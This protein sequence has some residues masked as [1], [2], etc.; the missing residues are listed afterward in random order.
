MANKI[1]ALGGL[2]VAQFTGAFNDNAF[3][4]F[5]VFF[6]IDR[7]LEPAPA[8]LIQRQFSQAMIAFVGPLLLGT[9]LAMAWLDRCSKRNVLVA[10]KF[11]EAS[12]FAGATIAI[13]L[14]GEFQFWMF[15]LISALG[16]QTAFLSPAKSSL[17]PGLV[18]HEKL[19]EANGAVEFVTFVAM[20]L[21]TWS[22]G[23]FKDQFA[24]HLWLIPLALL[25]LSLVGIAA[26]M[27]VPCDVPSV[28][29]GSNS[30]QR[31][32]GAL[33]ATFSQR[34]LFLAAVGMALSWFVIAMLVQLVLT[35]GKAAQGLGLN[36]RD[37][38][39]PIILAGIGAG[40]GSFWVGKL[41]RRKVEI[42]WIP[43][44]AAMLTLMVAVF[45]GWL[46]GLVGTA[47]FCAGVGMT[48]GFVLVPLNALLQWQAPEAKRG[49][50]IAVSN[51]A[52][53]AGL[54]GGTL[55]AQGVGDAGLGL[56]GS[57]LLIAAIAGIAT[58][59]VVR[60]FPE[61]L[62]RLCGLLLMRTVYR[63][64]VMHSEHIPQK[65]GALLI[66]NH[67]SFLD[68]L[69]LMAA[70][71]RPIR[72]IVEQH[73]YQKIWFNPFLRA[74]RA[75]PISSDQGPRI[76]LRAMKQAG[77]ALDDGEL[78]CLFAEGQIT[79]N[80]LLL[81]FRRGLER[82]IRGRRGLVIPVVLD[83]VWGS[84]FSRSQGRFLWKLP[85]RIP[86]RVTLCVGEPLPTSVSVHQVRQ[87]VHEL[88]AQ[89][90]NGRRRDAKT[91]EQHVLTRLRRRPTAPFAM[92]QGRPPLSS[93]GFLTL[94]MLL[95]RKLRPFRQE[96]ERMGV[97]LP[98]STAAS[99]TNVALALLHRVSVNLNFT[100]G[101]AAMESAIRQAHLKVI[102]S[103]R[104]FLQRLEL[105]LPEDITVLDVKELLDTSSMVSQ[106]MSWFLAMLAPRWWIDWSLGVNEERH[107]DDA[108]TV[109]FSS[110]STGEPKGVVLTHFNL[111][112]NIQ[113][114][115]QVFPFQREDRLLNILP[116]FH[117]FG[118]LCIWLTTTRR[119]PTIFHPLPTDAV[120][121]GELAVQHQA[122]L[123]M[124]TPTFLQLYLRRCSPGQFG[125]L[126]FVL[127]GAEKLTRRVADEFADRFGLRPL[128]GYGMTEC[129]PVVSLNTLD[130]RAPGF[131]QA[132]SRSGTVGKPLPGVAVR[133]VDPESREL[134][135]PGETG[136]ILVTGPNVMQGYL[137]RDDLTEQV[138]AD[139]WYE[140]GDL[141]CIDEDGFLTIT[142]RVSRFSKIGGEMVPHGKIEEELHR[143]A[144][145]PQ[146]AFVVV[147]VPDLRKG[148]KLVVLAT[149]SQD[150]IAGL[151]Q[152]LKAA[153]LP[154]L[155][156]PKAE[157]FHS[158]PEIPL[159]GTGKLD[160]ARAK[161]MAQQLTTRAEDRESAES[162]APAD[163]NAD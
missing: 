120:A 44:G 55:L 103:S 111:L 121:V 122:T 8:E 161:A 52:A 99:A 31:V 51:L 56:R 125:S 117:A 5:L 93:Q 30:R 110:G 40:L 6:A 102:V 141:G 3:R 134:K 13:A 62:L 118:L 113:G 25:S 34:P 144:D 107:V 35:Y 133:V 79:R 158:V 130:F 65:G 142:D 160:L 58:I 16:L 20:V 21:G 139:G 94:C 137:G 77:Q 29:I 149:L 154:N 126:R 27:R 43:F 66:S 46:P 100:A 70:T 60:M 12:I 104:E 138:L 127:T 49:A 136:L 22:G 7:L 155:Y 148:E 159:L 76:V 162:L 73:Y 115:D 150:R 84:L 89:A 97:L 36:D 156:V 152:D 11:V 151:I 37:A 109:L 153:G 15:G 32:W 42:G 145:L 129:S 72:F 26:A 2:L 80:G 24:G 9:V 33:T 87:A 140:T 18:S 81:P 92:E 23:F 114:I 163:S 14:T 10:M 50:V 47:L 86:Y 157:D 59:W 17:I 119:V 82:L 85:R 64:H 78:V 146:P 53:Y 48:L 123:L 88:G 128:E 124:A 38:G 108:L 57:F 68:G 98:T 45:A 61:A 63:L 19:S 74:M 131:F 69:F 96:H 90:W 54:F 39:L 116:S 105:K 106:A 101:P 83:R 135:S 1:S 4:L 75:I 71:D 112:A 143:I 95:A 91:L 67:V 28:S 147:G 41:S 132:G